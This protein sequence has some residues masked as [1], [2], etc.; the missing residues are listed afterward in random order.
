MIEIF[1]HLSLELDK[2]NKEKKQKL[3]KLKNQLENAEDDRG[4]RHCKLNYYIV[5]P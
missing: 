4:V 2:M 3:I 1:L 5:V